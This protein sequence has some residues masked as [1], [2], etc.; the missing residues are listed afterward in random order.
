MWVETR[1]VSPARAALVTSLAAVAGTALFAG[2]SA[3]ALLPA[4]PSALPTPVPSLPTTSGLPTI[5]GVPVPGVTIPPLPP[6][7]PGADATSAAGPGGEDAGARPARPPQ[8]PS[9][10]AGLL[11]VNLSPVERGAVLGA[12]LTLGFG[13]LAVALVI[14]DHLGVGPRRRLLR[15]RR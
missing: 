14:A 15:R 6:P 12:L 13:A 5:P 8:A 4:E 1:I 3:A 10:G 11:G 9:P 2:S 7:P